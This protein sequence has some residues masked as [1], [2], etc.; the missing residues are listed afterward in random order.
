MKKIF[1]V[2]CL[3]IGLLFFNVSPV[4]ASQPINWEREPNEEWSEARG[5][6]LIPYS[7]DYTLNQGYLHDKDDYDTWFF[8]ATAKEYKII[9]HPPKDTFYDVIVYEKDRYT[10]EK[11]IVFNTKD[12]FDNSKHIELPGIYDDGVVREYY[13]IVHSIWPSLLKPNE[14]YIIINADVN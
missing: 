8:N 1:P 9:M 11:K 13:V 10:G 7:D 14:P 12:I 4:S 2:I 5:N 6:Y 3:V